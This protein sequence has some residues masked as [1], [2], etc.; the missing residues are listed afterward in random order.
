MSDNI[1]FNVNGRLDR[2]GP[3]LLL[4]TL[5]LAFRRS[6]KTAKAWRIDKKLGLVLYW[7]DH[8]EATN[9]LATMDAEHLFPPILWYLKSKPDCETVGVDSNADHDGDNGP[10]W[11]VYCE[12]WGHVGGHWQ[13]FLA[14]KPAFMWYGK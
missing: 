1:V 4:A 7:T 10:G 2:D 5:K 12:D 14:I 9:F 13:A 11:R 8:P 3:E 6:R